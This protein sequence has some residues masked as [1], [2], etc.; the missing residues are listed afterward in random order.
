MNLLVVELTISLLVLLQVLP[1]NTT[2]SNTTALIEH[3]TTKYNYIFYDN[4]YIIDKLFFL[5]SK[6]DYIPT[7][8]NRFPDSTL[9]PLTVIH[10]GFFP[11]TL[12]PKTYQSKCDI[13][14]NYI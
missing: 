12:S 4:F 10:H 13:I 3:K 9:F 7:V 14:I 8:M 5:L 11:E 2:E 1:I 6:Y